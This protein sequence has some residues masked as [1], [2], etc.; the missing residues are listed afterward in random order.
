MPPPLNH[1][2]PLQALI[3]SLKKVLYNQPGGNPPKYRFLEKKNYILRDRDFGEAYHL[4]GCLQ[5]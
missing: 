2:I 1:T 5:L 4:Y 3:R